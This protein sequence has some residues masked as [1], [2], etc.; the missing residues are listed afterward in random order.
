MTTEQLPFNIQFATEF[1]RRL[2]RLS[3]RYRNV[4]ADLSPVI[5]QLKA[6]ELL[7]DQISGIDSVVMK[8]RVKNSDIQKGKSGG[9]RLIYWCSSD[10]LI[11]LVNIYS[12]SDQSNIDTAEIY[13]IITQFKVGSD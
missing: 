12:K 13:R 3:K 9:Y 8:V 5:E 2:K 4:K 10:E 11:V 1:K 7:G 6:G